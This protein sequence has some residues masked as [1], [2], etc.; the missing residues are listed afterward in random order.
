MFAMMTQ[1]KFQSNQVPFSKFVLQV[2]VQGRQDIGRVPEEEVRL[3][4][5]LHLPARP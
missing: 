2:E 1:K 4:V 3:Q 5:A